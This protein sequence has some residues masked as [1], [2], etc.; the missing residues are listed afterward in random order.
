MTRTNNTE[1][2]RLTVGGLLGLGTSTPTDRLQVNGQIRVGLVNPV[3]TGLLP[4]Y[5]NQIIFSGGNAGATFNSENSD[6]LWMSRYNASSDGTELRINLSD[7]CNAVDAFS[8]QSGGSGCAAN[9]EFFRMDATGAA[10]KPGGGAWA[11]LSDSRVKRDVN[12]F[13]DGLNIVNA[14]RPVTFQYNGLGHTF[15]GGKIYTG[16]IAQELQAIA[17]YMVDSQG[18]FL[19]VD[20]SAFTY[21]L[22][23]AV[24]EQQA[25]IAALKAKE[26]QTEAELSA[27]HGEI[28]AIKAALAK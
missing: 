20:P 3:N 22:L 5:G 9:T 11:T 2:M 13:T 24:K 25:Q 23:N 15:D 10:F 7:N 12:A 14:I 19:T 6:P 17:P 28:E 27:L 21:I 4:S 18:E 16:V 26:S 1:Q 8:I